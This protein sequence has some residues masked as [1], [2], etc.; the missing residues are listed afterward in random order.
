MVDGE[1]CLES[2]RCLSA[3]LQHLTGVVDEDVDLPVPLEQGRR[4]LAHLVE[5]GEVA[6]VARHRA[7]TGSRHLVFGCRQ[8]VGVP[9]DEDDVG[10]LPRQTNR[11]LFADA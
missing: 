5:S 3:L 9:C 4:E 7:V 1:R 11:G 2:I 6:C 8:P 10:T